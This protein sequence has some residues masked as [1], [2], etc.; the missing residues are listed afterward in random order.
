MGNYVNK[1]K[2]AVIFHTEGGCVTVRLSACM[3][4]NILSLYKI[5]VLELKIEILKCMFGFQGQ[6]ID[7]SM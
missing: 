3:L 5:V 7:F 1:K 6:A 2:I 4:C